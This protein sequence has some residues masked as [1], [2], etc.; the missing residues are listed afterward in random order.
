MQSAQA[1]DE[2]AGYRFPAVQNCSYIGGHFSSGHHIALELFPTDLGIGC[3]KFHDLFL[4]PLEIPEGLRST[5]HQAG[6]PHRMNGHAGS[7]YNKRLLGAD[8]QRNSNRVAAAQHKRNG[9]F[10]HS[11]DQ[12]GDGKARFNIAANGI[13][14]QQKPINLLAL[15][16]PGQ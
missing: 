1:V 16:Y 7:G 9:G 12:L 14:Q 8:R 2:A 5:Y 4:N 13:Q 3:N 6:H 11:G 15:L 10:F